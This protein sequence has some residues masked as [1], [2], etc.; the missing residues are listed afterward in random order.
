MDIFHF[1]TS[2]SNYYRPLQMLSYSL[3]YFFWRLNPIGY[4]LMNILIHSLN[5]FLEF[6]LLYLV[7]K[8]KIL[9]L[10]AAVFFCVHPIH[11]GVVSVIGGRSNILEE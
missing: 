8:D 2:P 7:F 10:F 5:S 1:A 4:H 9:A 3:D 11:I 6:L